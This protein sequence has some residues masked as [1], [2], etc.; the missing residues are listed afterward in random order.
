MANTAKQAPTK[1]TKVTCQFCGKTITKGKTIAQ[2]HGARCANIQAQFKAAG[3]MQAHYKKLSV[4]VIPKGFITVG[5]LDKKVKAQ[6]HSIAGL[7]ISKMVKGF[8]TDRASKPP[9]HPIMQVYYLPNRHRVIHGWLA[10]TQG[11]NA[12]ASG[13]FSQ[14][15]K[16]PTVQTI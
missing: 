6:A 4:A 13:N 14:A 10:T 12:I 8:G 1:P 5:A 15:P 16:P 9:A 11:L 3:S 7:T 2:G